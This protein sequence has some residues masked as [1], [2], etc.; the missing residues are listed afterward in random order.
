MTPNGTRSAGVMGNPEWAHDATFADQFG[1][2]K[3]RDEID[4]QVCANGRAITIISNCGDAAGGRSR[5]RARCSIASSSTRTRI[6]GMGLFVEDSTITRSASGFSRACRCRM[7]NVPELNYSYPPDLGQHNR[8]IF[9]GL[10][11]L[12]DAEI[13]MLM[14][15]K[16]IY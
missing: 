13:N 1:R 3:H 7:S 6:L 12:S 2:R 16:V 9:G 11:G 10:L 8:D 5:R 4:R 15:E 14:E